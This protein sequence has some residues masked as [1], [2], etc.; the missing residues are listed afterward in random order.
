MLE[1]ALLEGPFPNNC[2]CKT[3]RVFSRLFGP[4]GKISK[5]FNSTNKKAYK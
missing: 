2:S 5:R 1:W 3:T 4:N